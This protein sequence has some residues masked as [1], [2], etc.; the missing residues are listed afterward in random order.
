MHRKTLDGT[1][2]NVYFKKLTYPEKKNYCGF[3]REFCQ[4]LIT[5]Q[6]VVQLLL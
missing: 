6:F 4:K 1:L 2:R 5:P 3:E